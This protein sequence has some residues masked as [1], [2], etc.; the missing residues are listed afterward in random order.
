M[1]LRMLLTNSRLVE[2]DFKT[3]CCHTTDGRQGMSATVTQR[4]RLRHH[5]PSQACGR[6]R[7]QVL[8]HSQ[9]LF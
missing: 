4:E 8:T 5:F 6:G 2:K 9:K 3:D 1:Q 7:N